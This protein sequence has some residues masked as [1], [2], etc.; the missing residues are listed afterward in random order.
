[1]SKQSKKSRGIEEY[2][3]I[4][5]IPQYLFQSST[6]DAH[7]V[8]LFL[9]GGPGSAASLFA[10]AFQAG[11]EDLFTVVHWDQRGSGKTL[12]RNPRAYPTVDLLLQDVLEIAR[13]LKSRYH[14]PRIVILGHSWGSVLGSLFIQRHPEEVAYYIGVGQV[15]NKLASERIGY[16][17]VREAI[18]Q[19]NDRGALRR[20]DAL[21]DYPGERLDAQWLRKS[22][23]LRKLQAHLHLTLKSQ[24][25]PLKLLLSSPLFQLSDLSALIKWSKANQP[26]MTFLGD[27]DLRTYP[28]E[29]QV[30]LYYVAGEQD[31]QTPVALTQDYVRG[32]TAP[33]KQ[34]YTVPNAG[35]MTMIDQPA[36]FLNIMRDINH[37]QEQRNERASTAHR[38]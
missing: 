32:I 20:L 2:V 11:W 19:A 23:E 9:H 36:R 13:Y 16:A 7:P 24:V 27:F 34:I 38:A 28:A 22:L 17:K 10:H 31:W 14:Q 26:L 30:P 6:S 15:I 12:T 3:E 25:S 35:H 18:L 21:G 37:R 33:E 5:G 29:Y 8:L 4:N 1:M